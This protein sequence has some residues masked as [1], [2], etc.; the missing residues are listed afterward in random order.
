MAKL[1]PPRYRPLKPNKGE[2]TIFKMFEDSNGTDDWFVLNSLLQQ[3]HV[4]KKYGEIDFLVLAPGYGIF[5][6]EVKGSAF[7]N[8]TSNGKW[9]YFDSNH[10][11]QYEKM[12]SPFQQANSGMHSL[13]NYI[14][15]KLGRFYKD[16]NYGYGVVFTMVDYT[17]SSPEEEDHM[18]YNSIKMDSMTIDKFIKIMSKNF[19]LKNKTTQKIPDKDDIKAILKILRGDFEY[20]PS[21]SNVLEDKNDKIKKFTDHQ[22]EIF[23]SHL[24]HERILV[25]GGPGTG[26][27]IIAIEVAKRYAFQKK[28]TLLTCFNRHLGQWLKGNFN[29]EELKYVTVG[30]IH[31]IVGILLQN[32]NLS[33]ERFLEEAPLALLDLTEKGNFQHYDVLII[34]ETQDLINQAYLDIFSLILKDGLKAGEWLMFGDFISQT[35]FT[36]HTIGSMYSIINQR[37]DEELHICELRK[38]IRNTKE[39]GLAAVNLSAPSQ[40]PYRLTLDRSGPYAVN[41]FDN[42]IMQ[43]EKIITMFEMF[44]KNK[45]D[46]STIIVL[47]PYKIENSILNKMT[48][49]IPPISAYSVNQNDKNIKF[50]TIQSFK[51]L[52]MDHV[53][54]LDINDISSDEKMELLFNAA[55]RSTYSLTLMINS[56]LKDLFI[57]RKLD[58]HDM[59]NDELQQS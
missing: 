54:I 6:I 8:R 17:V 47:S 22:L 29:S 55:T 58:T 14:C 13:K 20:V 4:G 7:I 31:S 41:F 38:N 27:T 35:L 50:A 45:Y 46:P 51:G 33:F 34:D 11:L 52:E 3:R 1:L 10:N 28:R 44:K 49:K 19:H 25:N 9:Q 36:D 26:K 39:T 12:E 5:C 23:D 53:V 15:D 30:N 59:Y 42:E 21:M 37:I 43:K 57:T 16:L 40:K 24:N 48:D 2:K 56:L 32:S 18:I